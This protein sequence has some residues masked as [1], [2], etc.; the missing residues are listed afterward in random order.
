MIKKLF[1]LYSFVEIEKKLGIN[2]TTDGY[3][4]N[5]IISPH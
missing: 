1:Y 3:A 4:V 5:A 2:I